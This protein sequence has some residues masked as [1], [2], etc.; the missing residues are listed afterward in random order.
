[1]I[2]S[3]LLIL[4]L[5]TTPLHIL[6]GIVGTHFLAQSISTLSESKELMLHFK[7]ESHR[8]ERMAS[9]RQGHSSAQGFPD[10]WRTLGFTGGSVHM[11][12]GV[13]LPFC[14]MG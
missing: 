10:W 12:L 13:M 1:M 6:G 4:R 14:S 5:L 9:D 3:I 8:G 11:T 2:Y 7:E